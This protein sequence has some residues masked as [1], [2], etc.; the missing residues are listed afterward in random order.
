M[1]VEVE[2]VVCGVKLGLVWPELLEGE[3]ID[4]DKGVV[5]VGLAWDN[6]GAAAAESPA[7]WLKSKQGAWKRKKWIKQKEAKDLW[8]P[9]FW[10]LMQRQ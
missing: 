6:E 9:Q 7:M 4:C 10:Q 3:A 1:G 8:V 2:S 5:K